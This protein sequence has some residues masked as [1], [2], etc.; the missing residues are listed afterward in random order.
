M[1]CRKCNSKDTRVTVT[2]HHGNETWRYCRC[3]KC[4]TNFKTIETY[5]ILKRGSI[6]GV[7]QHSNCI[8]RGEQS[9]TSVLTEQNVRDIRLLAETK[10]TYKEIAERYGIHHSTVYRI[11]KRKRWSH[12]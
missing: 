1:N 3:L 6:P 10:T 4:G 5:A 11:V 9:G 7:P 8:R 2:E 12:I